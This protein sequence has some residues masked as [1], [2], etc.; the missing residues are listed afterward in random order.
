M[1]DER[2]LWLPA[3]V[4]EI[5]E[6]GGAVLVECGL[7]ADAR[8]LFECLD[9]AVVGDGVRVGVF[10]DDDGRLLWI[11]AYFAGTECDDVA[12][13][14]LDLSGRDCGDALTV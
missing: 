8:V 12:R 5:V 6:V 13:E 3:N 4:R 11:G 1:S 9:V 14:A 7:A 2:D 10:R